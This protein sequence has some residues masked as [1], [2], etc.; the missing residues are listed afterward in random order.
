MCVFVGDM[1]TFIFQ[2]PAAVNKI[3]EIMGH[4]ADCVSVHDICCT[5]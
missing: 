4:R 5:E 2:T 1:D 3:K